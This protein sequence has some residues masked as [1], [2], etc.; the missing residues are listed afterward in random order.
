MLVAG[1]IGFTEV[2]LESYNEIFV[3]KADLGA[4][5][6]CFANIGVAISLIVCF[7]LFSI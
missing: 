2:G 4:K 3:I 7:E 1:S 6:E 5:N